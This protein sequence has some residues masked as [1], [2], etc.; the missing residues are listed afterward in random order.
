MKT[1]LGRISSVIYGNSLGAT[2]PAKQHSCSC[3]TGTG[4]LKIGDV[5]DYTHSSL[6]SFLVL[7]VISNSH[8]VRM[9]TCL[10]WGH[11]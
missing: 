11:M 6:L 1:A 5:D 9:K 3:R 4:D 10:L 7:I 2:M 8:T